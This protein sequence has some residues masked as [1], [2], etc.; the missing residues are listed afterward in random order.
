MLTHQLR[1]NL[2]SRKGV[3]M[4]KYGCAKCYAEIET[5]DNLSGKRE[6]CPL[7]RE[8]NYVPLSEQ[9]KKRYKQAKNQHKLIKKAAKKKAMTAA[10]REQRQGYRNEC[11][12]AYRKQQQIEESKN[13][14][15][16]HNI[17]CIISLLIPIVGLF[18][19]ISLLTRKDARDRYTGESCLVMSGLGFVISLF[20]YMLMSNIPA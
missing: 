6:V 10:R 4:I 8:I 15:P 17:L 7:C 12:S 18:I 2:R 16:S 1:Q 11:I 19:S 20:L 5:T 14:I 3:E 9:V 13:R